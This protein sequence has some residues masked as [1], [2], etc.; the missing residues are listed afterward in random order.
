MPKA[1]ILI[2]SIV[3]VFGYLLFRKECEK[4]FR[5]LISE[6]DQREENDLY[7]PEEL[8]LREMEKLGFPIEPEDEPEMAQKYEIW[9]ILWN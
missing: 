7:E 3:S 8:M 9:V 6:A 1:S 4:G 5:Q 2:L